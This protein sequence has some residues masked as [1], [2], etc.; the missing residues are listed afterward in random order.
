MRKSGRWKMQKKIN[1]SI[2]SVDLTIFKTYPYLRELM[3]GAFDTAWTLLK[4]EPTMRGEGIAAGSHVPVEVRR[5]MARTGQINPEMGVSARS[6]DKRE[7]RPRP[8]KGTDP[9]QGDETN[10]MESPVMR[11]TEQISEMED[12][13]FPLKSS[14]FDAAWVLLKERIDSRRNKRYRDQMLFGVPENQKDRKPQ[15]ASGQSKR[16]P[17]SFDAPQKTSRKQHP[18]TS[19]G[20]RNP[21]MTRKPSGAMR[22]GAVQPAAGAPGTSQEEMDEFMRINS[23]EEYQDMLHAESLRDG[24]RSPADEMRLRG[25]QSVYSR[26]DKAAGRLAAAD[27]MH[28]EDI[29]N[30][31]EEQGIPVR[32][33][34]ERDAARNVFKPRI[35]LNTDYGL[36]TALENLNPDLYHERTSDR[37]RRNSYLVDEM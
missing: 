37:L 9:M 19:Y 27:V 18:S 32:S 23:P 10:P 3:S 12:E 4:D 5:R 16:V 21:A 30:I 14:A 29:Q 1:R 17:S 20:E 8:P 7:K 36:R 31:F 6:P 11:T 24:N 28:G 34:V 25:L 22:T 35:E 2:C 26:P 13:E 33:S 15:R